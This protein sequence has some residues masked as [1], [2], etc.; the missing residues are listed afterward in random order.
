MDKLKREDGDDDADE[1]NAMEE[2]GTSSTMAQQ[3]QE[4]EEVQDEQGDEQQKVATAEG[5]RTMLRGK[6]RNAAGDGQQQLHT[7]WTWRL[8]R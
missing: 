5:M 4:K 6:R 7:E 2:E 1:D 8:M 3:Q